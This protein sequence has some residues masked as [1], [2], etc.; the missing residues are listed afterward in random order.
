MQ[1]EAVKN[2]ERQEQY[3]V[4]IEPHFALYRY[5]KVIRELGYRTLVLAFHPDSCLAGERKY[6]QRLDHYH[7]SRIDA[8]VAYER[9]DADGF[10]KA[11][12][13]YRDRIAGIVAGEDSM[14]PLAAE[15]GAALGF[16][17][18][19]PEDARCHHLKTAMKERLAARGVRTPGFGIAR[20]LGQALEIWKRFDGDCMVKM[21]D[22]AAS[23]NVFRVTSEEQ[24]REAWA[25]IIDNRHG[26]KVPFP[27]A[28]EVILEEFVPGRE[29]TAE[30][31]VAGERIEFLNFSEKLTESNFIVVGHYIPAATTEAE[32][33]SL[34]EIATQCIRALGLRNSLFHVE[35]HLR[36]GVPYVIE[37]AA[38]PPGQHAVELIEKSY[39]ID[40]MRI[41][42]DLATGREATVTRSAP[43]AHHAILAL[44]TRRSGTLERIEG[45]DA[46][47]ARGG[48]EH[49]VVN[50]KPGD[51]VR[52]LDT[53]QDKYGLL[54]LADEDPEGLREK[55]DWARENVRLVVAPA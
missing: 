54:I 24:L 12:A 52:S 1:T 11:L 22:F 27:L 44:Y 18:A 50:V 7:G 35:V 36:D 20:N 23:L 53:F 34:R 25:A 45:I 39:G 29:L 31:Y 6:S 14:V 33:R 17:Y 26:L 13:P 3:V 28:S 21:V 16:D 15:I 48:A 55:A 10:L 5:L 51:P 43:R 37:C 40:L 32:E 38:R 49:V 42:V 19:R 46:L 41:S 30:G 47:H 8:L 2:I 4:V 9:F